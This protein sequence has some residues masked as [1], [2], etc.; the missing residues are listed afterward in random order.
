MDAVLQ[1]R[2]AP[3]RNRDLPGPK[4]RFFGQQVLYLE[5]PGF[6]EPSAAEH[7]M[8][9]LRH[10]QLIHFQG[11]FELR[12]EATDPQRRVGPCITEASTSTTPFQSAWSLL[13][14]I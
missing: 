14:L 13:K 9:C 8:V 3:I 1:T 10:H 4:T 11:L 5:A 6:G 2:F 12:R 7:D